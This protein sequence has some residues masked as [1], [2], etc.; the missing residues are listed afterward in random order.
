MG[1][2]E[3]VA[4]RRAR[5][6][7]ALAPRP[8]RPRSA[9]ASAR[10]ATAI[11][12]L[13]G[14]WTAL[15]ARAAEPN[16]FAEHWFVAASL[17]TLARG[18][19][20]R[21]L[22]VRRGGRLIGLL[23]LTIEQ[24][25]AHLPVRFVQNWCHD[26]AFLGT[27]LVAAGEERRLLGRRR[28]A[29]LDEA[30][31][32]PGFLHLRGLAEDGPVHRGA[33]PR[34]DRPPP[35]A[36][37][38]LDKRALARRPITSR[39]SARRSARSSAACATASPSSARSAPPSSTIAAELAAW[40]D[41]LSRARE[42][43]L[44]GRG[45]HRA[46]LRRRG[47]RP[48]SATPLAGAWA[49]GRLQFLRLDVGGRA[50]A[51]LVNF[52]TPPGS[53]S[54][55]TVF[56]E[57]Y[58]RFS[59]GVLIQLENLRHPR[60]PGHRL[61]GQLRDRGSSDDRQPLDASAA[62]SSASPCRLKG[63]RRRAVY[64]LC[65]GARARLGGW[66]RASGCDARAAD[67]RRHRGGVRLD[68]AFLAREPWRRARSRPRRA[69]MRSTTASAW[70]RPMSST[71]RSRPI[72]TRWPS[73]SGLR[74]AGKA[75]IGAHL[76]PWVTPP[77]EE[78]VT[79][80]NSYHCNLPPALERAKIEAL[81][82]AIEQSLRRAARPSSRPAATASGRTPRESLAELGYRVDCSLVPHTDFSG[83]GGPDFRG[84][85]DRPHW[86]VGRPA[87]SAADASAFSARCRGSA[88]KADWLFDS[89]APARLRLPGVLAR[90]RASSP[91]RG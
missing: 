90:S 86:L 16:P 59:P 35:G 14:E 20:V 78:A 31:W 13:A 41:D 55:K 32:A 54:F 29:L 39:R 37:A 68:R 38:L 77:H 58:A 5:A 46:R 71:I 21:L 3:T 15:A 19:D 23:P 81:T 4:D 69:P 47:P 22:E 8:L 10:L 33:R 48:S 12:G 27:P 49:A 65:R 45:G 60:R 83:D 1:R 75:E 18:R 24:G 9:S 50:I 85:P 67:R 82:G 53:F 11:D 36:R 89:P 40:C 30:D 44:E 17:P 62:R 91:A 74:E 7:R 42:S 43:G 84:R 51:M 66:S 70:F 52:L 87:R 34:R 26:Q 28:S 80:C 63:A 2:I 6:A 73:C 72:P 61:D 64:A 88:S 79:T 76:H 57:D 25:Y 56:D